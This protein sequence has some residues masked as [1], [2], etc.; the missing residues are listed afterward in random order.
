M[1]PWLTDSFGGGGGHRTLAGLMLRRIWSSL[2]IST[3]FQC[4]MCPFSPYS[5]LLYAGG[6]LTLQGTAHKTFS[7]PPH[8]TTH[9]TTLSSS[10]STSFCMLL[11]CHSLPTVPIP[12]KLEVRT[13][14]MSHAAHCL[15][16]HSLLYG[17]RAYASCSTTISA[18]F[19]NLLLPLPSLLQH[20][21]FKTNSMALP[22]SPSLTN[23]LP[24]L[25]SP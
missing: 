6:G 16:T 21:S 10:L 2:P 23:N 14:D 15:V 3:H 18:L 25:P 17:M 19:P 7:P 8:L 1:T 20:G 4:I 9:H 24:P 5:L 12:H 11:H 22:L 13:L